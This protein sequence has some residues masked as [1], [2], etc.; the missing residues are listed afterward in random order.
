MAVASIQERTR[1]IVAE[2]EELG[3][4]VDRYRYL[5]ELGEKMAPLPESE[6]TDETRLPGCQY[7]LWIRTDYDAGDDALR[8]LVHSDAR[9]TRGL[10]ALIVRV[11]DGQ[12]PSVV[13]DAELEFLDEVGLRSHL[14]SQRNS[15]LSAMIHEMKNRARQHRDAARSPRQAAS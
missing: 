8:F 5:V 9:I 12:P 13:A 3:D 4:W 6:R 14:S 2:F 15:G 7:G 10:A 11:L 1:E